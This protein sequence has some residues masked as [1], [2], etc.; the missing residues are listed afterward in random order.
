MADNVGN[1]RVMLDSSTP[2]PLK[3]GQMA[4]IKTKI[5]HPMESGFRKDPKTGETVPAHH[6]TEI[7][8]E[9]MGKQVIKAEVTGA[10]S[11]D[12]FFAFHVKA[13]ASGPVKVTWKDNKGGS[14][15][16][17]VELQVQ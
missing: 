16:K 13:E 1:P 9:Y 17:S 7:V 14:W 3:K 10:V 4:K 5:G 6:I 11:K 2:N 15:D 8:V 12:P